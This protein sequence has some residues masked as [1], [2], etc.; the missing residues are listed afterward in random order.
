[1]LQLLTSPLTARTVRGLIGTVADA[2]RSVVAPAS[3]AER[4]ADVEPVTA[5]DPAGLYEADELPD[6]DVIEAAAR[7]YE[8]A[9]DQARR[10]DRGKRAAKK[11]LD[12]L[13]AGIY[14]GWKVFRTPSSRQT[15]D[16]AEITRIFKENGLG[17]VPMKACAPSLKVVAVDVP[18]VPV[19]V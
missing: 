11:V 7:E 8:R 4:Q 17:Q 12:R 19:A 14:G 18:A 1:M 2:V 13:P 6:T 10:A 3:L 16:L 5:P 15:P 9:A